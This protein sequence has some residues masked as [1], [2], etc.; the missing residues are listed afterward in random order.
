MAPILVSIDRAATAHIKLIPRTDRIHKSRGPGEGDARD[1]S[2]TP[3]VLLLVAVPGH[4]PAGFEARTLAGEPAVGDIQSLAADGSLTIGGRT[5]PA[6]Q[7]YSARRAGVPL[8]A[9][10]RAPHAEL[11][12]GGRLV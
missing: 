3:A 11:N 1:E 5:V 8:P 12:A 10:P 4:G 7:W 9:W 2:M 6:G